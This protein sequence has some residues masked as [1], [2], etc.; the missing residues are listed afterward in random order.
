MVYCCITVKNE[1]KYLKEWV[2]YHLN[3]GIGKIF[4]IDNNDIDGEVITDIDYI[5]ECVKNYKVFIINKR[6]ENFDKKEFYKKIYR[7]VMFNRNN[8]LLLLDIDEFLIDENN[9]LSN[10]LFKNRLSVTDIINIPCY[11]VSD[12]NIIT[13]ENN[14]YSV[15][16]RFINRTNAIYTSRS[17]IRG[18]SKK[19]EWFDKNGPDNNY[20]EK[21]ENNNIYINKYIT[22]STQE[23]CEKIEKNNYS[24]IQDKI[25]EYFKY[26]E[27]SEEKENYLCERLKIQH[28][29]E[30]EIILND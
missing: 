7:E 15:L 26:N 28:K 14:N 11:I 20:T 24:N 23:W 29:S 5:N 16:D 21:I 8:W 9:Q 22:K 30:A 25:D 1:N 4:I 2:E 19:L 12:N 6:G 17:L 18:K 27:Y 13:V 10:I 3:I